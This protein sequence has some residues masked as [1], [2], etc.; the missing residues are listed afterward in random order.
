MIKK[1]CS[2][3]LHID[4]VGVRKAKKE[5]FQQIF[6][7]DKGFCGY[8]NSLEKNKDYRYKVIKQE[9]KK[10]L[11]KVLKEKDRIMLV[12]EEDNKIIGYL[13]GN[14]EKSKSKGINQSLKKVG[15]IIIN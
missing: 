7:L 1:R 10:H 11:I 2:F 8:N 9:R 13:D 6:K 4:R 12:L 5:D 3:G 15:Y 14:V